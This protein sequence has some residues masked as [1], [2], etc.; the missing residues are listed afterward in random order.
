[1]HDEVMASGWGKDSDSAS[2]VSSVLREV[3]IPI[4][5]DS[6]CRTAY[7]TTNFDKKICISALG[8]HGTCN[9]S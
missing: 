2:G 8:G 4:A 1:M 6:V 9:V 7:P 3:V 5:D